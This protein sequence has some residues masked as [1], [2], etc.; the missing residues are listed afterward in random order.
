MAAVEPLYPEDDAPWVPVDTFGARLALIRQ[1][2]GGWNVKKTAQ[3]C[4]LDDQTWRNWEAGT[5]PRDYEDVCRLIAK[6]VGC[7]EAWLK[8]GG[9][10]RSRCFSEF[11]LTE[12][13][14][15]IGKTSEIPG[16]RM[17]ALVGT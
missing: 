11:D 1:K 9:P 17:F 5:S 10:L 15:V 12:G 13:L 6:A 2:L 14:D 16:Q 4:G 7:S 8:A 3:F